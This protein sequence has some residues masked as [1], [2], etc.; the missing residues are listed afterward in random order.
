MTENETALDYLRRVVVELRRCR[1][2][3]RELEEGGC[4][5]VAVVGMGCRFPG[6]VGC[7]DD[8][9]DLVVGEGDAIGPFPSDRYWDLGRLFDPDPDRPGVCYVREGGFLYGAADFD[10]EFFHISPREALAMDPQQRQLLEVAWEALEHAGINPQS[11]HG[12]P[13][14]IYTGTVRQEYGPPLHQA[15]DDV[16]GHRLTGVSGS[17]VSGRVAYALGLEGAAVS[18]DTACSSSLVAVHLACQ[19]LRQGHCSLALAGG[20]TVMSTPGT[21]TEFA[22][23]RGLAPDGRCKPFAAAADGT[24]FAEGAALLVLERLGD[25]RRHQHCVLALIRGSAINEDGAS[26][27]LSAPSGPAQQRVIFQALADARLSPHDIDAVEAHGTGTT[28]GDPI[29]A[30][31]L[32]AAYGRERPAG[33]PL[34]LGSVK[35]NIGH[36]QAAAG[37][38]GLIKMV[39]ALRHGVLPRSLHIDR[40]TPHVDWSADTVRLLT[41]TRPWPATARARRAAVSS[42]GI[43]G[44]NAHIILEQPPE[45]APPPPAPPP[46]DCPQTWVLSAHTPR[47]LQDQAERIH[48]HATAQPQLPA[49]DIAHALASTRAALDRR[50]AVVGRTREDLLDGLAA[51]AAERRHR[52]TVR[53]T[54]D[55]DRALVVLFAGQGAQHAGMGHQLYRT[56][57]AFTQ[58]FDEVCSA[59]DP[60][61]DRPLRDVVFAAP[62]SSDAALIH[63]TEYTQPA[64]F[65]METALFRML[66]QHGI[67]PDHLIGHSIGELTAAH[68]AGIL[69]LPDACT[70]VAARGRLMQSLPSGG[71]MIAVHASEAEVLPQ[72]RSHPRH[73][74]IAAVNTPTSIVISGHA[75]AVREI[76][77]ELGRRGKRT[78]PLHVSHAFHSPCIEPML[79]DF[80]AIA[81]GL[82]FHRPAIPIISTLT[83]GPVAPDK[84][85]TPR[86]WAE[87]ARHTVRFHQALDAITR[88]QPTTLLEIG[89]DSTLTAIAHSCMRDRTP[90]SHTAVPALRKGDCEANTL[91]IAVAQ[92][93]AH[94]HVGTPLLPDTPSVRRAPLPTYP[95][96]RQRFWLT[97]AP[98]S[99]PSAAAR[100]IGA[101]YGDHPLVGAVLT[102]P[103]ED[104]WVLSGR[105]S[106]ESHPWLADHV[107]QA[108]RLLPATVFLELALR[109]AREAACACVEELVLQ[110]PLVF[111]E[112]GAVQLRTT[113]GAADT[114]GRRSLHISSRAED[115]GTAGEWIRHAIAVLGPEAAVPASSSAPWPPADADEVDS[116]DIHDL[117]AAHGV[118]YGP[119]F[120]GLTAAWRRDGEAFAVAEAPE[121]IRSETSLFALH[122]A[123]LDGA[124]HAL[125]LCLPDGAGQALP[126]SW[127][128]VTL[129]A[130]GASALRVHLSRIGER[131]IAVTARDNTG[132]AVLTAASLAMRPIE[133]TRSDALAHE[134][135]FRLTWSEQ[136]LPAASPDTASWAVLG[137][138]TN[139]LLADA[140]F[141]RTHPD[142]AS[143][144]TALDGGASA[145]DIVIA[146]TPVGPSHHGEL[147]TAIHTTAH[148]VLALVQDWLA[149]ARFA[150]AR[151]VVL[152]SG[153]VATRT[154]EDICDLPAAA[155]WGLLRS[156]QNEHPQRFTLLDLDDHPASSSILARALATAEPQLAI[157]AGALFAPG[158]TRA[159]PN[160]ATPTGKPPMNQNG[161]VLITGGTGA[162]GGLLARHLVTRHD[163][164]HVLLVSRQ[165]AKAPGA[166]R[167]EREL[168]TLGASVTL[169]ACDISDRQAVARILAAIPAEHP[170]T[171]VIHMAGTLDDGVLA[172]LTPERCD[173]VLRAKADGAWH[174]HDLTRHHNLAAFILYSSIAGILGNAGQGNYAAANTFLDALAHHRAAHG[175][176]AQSL[177]WG[178][179][180]DVG[181]AARLKDED[182]QRIDHLGLAPMPAADALMLFDTALGS[183]EP[184]VVPA[185]LDL[186]TLRSRHEP[187]AVPPALRNLVH[188]RTKAP[189]NNH[190]AAARA[191]TLHQE[192]AGLD[193]DG[194]RA[195][196]LDLIRRTTATA[197]GHRSDIAADIGFRALGIDSL[198]AIV[199][200]NHLA[201]VTGLGLPSTLVFDHPTPTALARHLDEVLLHTTASPATQITAWLD[202]LD[203]AFSAT[204]PDET[205]RATGLHHMRELLKK[206][207]SSKGP[208]PA[209]E[210]NLVQALEEAADTELFDFIEEEL[211]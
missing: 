107:V 28:L 40:P 121:A 133:Q 41:A 64:L 24:G 13:T 152:T 66:E 130:P 104:S 114:A 4:E 102:L 32:L 79:R 207:G 51:L 166:E 153:A 91:A 78:S 18:V 108:K 69:T 200:R 44:T 33:R 136:L 49:A 112:R 110:A 144:A 209:P 141:T 93:Y 161:T 191:V 126:F 17:V 27:D 111:P 146:P 53:G 95:F 31:A 179:W 71:A 181:M 97:P 19:A 156:A 211:S 155:L 117:F 74:A 47:A 70:L 135:L 73:A 90:H 59:I 96:Q 7:A 196:L 128:R 83:G 92:L 39:M 127:T 5:P 42:F 154:G 85:T 67:H 122:P 30:N 77:D 48:A 11:L 94:G 80:Q 116:S 189:H 76:A 2:R 159:A 197:L 142:L 46:G 131:E 143:L 36:T 3:V 8:L 134:A 100:A 150:H 75:E 198:T 35:S 118:E 45:E 138:L 26:S 9:W 1:E 12:T 22:R 98:S 124:L 170:L 175:L 205:A 101:E 210:H 89:P 165:G 60:H 187:S 10:A 180:R 57:P 185:R 206:Y 21:F 183:A 164:R 169:A 65:A 145:P 177:A 29:E 58:A 186:T 174:L 137:D 88:S 199:L 52:S 109:A 84:M 123:L 195:V 182:S 208:A 167:L 14:A 173:S 55:A 106:L 50:A 148:Q 157:R 62:Q 132:Q 72:V 87:Q 151:L 56:Q 171:A 61:L 160:S 15:S 188:G 202:K 38:A 204:A 149:D 25:A 176:P 99:T 43:S 147:P 37:A 125:S 139:G 115:T 105:L 63:R 168:V 34:W 158:L 23:Q 140:P 184:A 68:I 113:V 163:V 120:R 119:A 192:L 81:A 54:A 86:Y 201:S 203:A 16:A 103:D 194:R 82:D 172:N 178:W 190:T 6:G 193:E 129:H 20:V 162:L